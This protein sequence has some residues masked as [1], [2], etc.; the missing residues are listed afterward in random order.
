MIVL[1]R[2]GTSAIM[3]LDVQ[4]GQHLKASPFRTTGT[5]TQAYEI[6]IDELL[7]FIVSSFI[8]QLSD[9]RKLF[10]GVVIIRILCTARP[11][12]D[13][14][15]YY[16]FLF[17]SFVRRHAQPAITQ[18]KCFFPLGSRF[19]KMYLQRTL[20]CGKGKGYQEQTKANR[21]F[22]ESIFCSS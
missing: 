16:F 19:I 5:R 15:Q 11:E 2:R 1:S 8:Q 13:I 17:F 18:W 6:F 3:V 21:S 4:I 7:R 22:H 20:L 10:V 12:G 14:I 9:G